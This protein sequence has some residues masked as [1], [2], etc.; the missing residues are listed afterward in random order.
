M[1]N[2]ILEAIR[3]RLSDPFWKNVTTL[4][5]GS[6]LAQALPIF[7]LPFVTRIY[8]KAALGFYFVY[9]AMGLLTQI[10]ASLQYQLAIVLPKTAKDADKLLVGNLMLV[11]L[12]SI[13]LFVII[14]VFF[15][16]IASFIDQKQ[17]LLWL[18]ALPASTFFLG[19]FNAI[20]YY[21]NRLKKFKAISYGKVSKSIAFSALQIVLGLWGFVN[22]GL[23]IG[24]IAGQAVSMVFMLYYL[25]QKTNF[26]FNFS[27]TEIKNLLVKYKDIPVFN[28]VI[29]FLNT[30]S[31]QLPI[32][33]LTRYFG[34]SAAGDY[35][36]ANRTITTPMGLIGQSVG[37]VFYQEAAVIQNKGNALAQLVKTTYL[38]LLKLGVIP[39][40]LFALWAPWLFKIVFSTDYYISGVMTRILIP[41]LFVMFLNSPITF[42]VTVLNKQRQMLWYDV[43]LLLFRF[44]ALWLGYKFFNNILYTIAF[45]SGVGAI[46]NILLLFYFVHISKTKT[47]QVYV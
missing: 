35:G 15:D 16:F 47:N 27:F 9:A 21:F 29:S 44:L 12:S 13:L 17:F 14:V 41:W 10:V 39:F 19:T 40:F 38:R 11:G 5:T 30:L 20:S 43:F 46:F 25:R 22:G 7:I 42:I 31:N 24:L 45:Y 33:L 34:A 3:H 36:L 6:A 23:I 4:F 32:F 8:P 1:A 26:T 37:Q 28:T 2:K 18:Y